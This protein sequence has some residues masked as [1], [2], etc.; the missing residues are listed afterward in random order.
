MEE[1]SLHILDIVQ[2]SVKAQ[3]DTVFITVCEDEKN[4]VLEI[5][6][7]DNGCGM[8]KEFLSRVRDP[9]TTTRKT[10][11]AGLGISLFEAA[12]VQSGGSFDIDSELGKGTR[13]TA[14]FGY[15]SIDR[16]PL[17]DMAETAVTLISGSPDIRFVYTHIKNGSRFVLDTDELKKILGGIS[18]SEPEV[19]SWIK[20]YVREGLINL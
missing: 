3:A 14:R 20:D 16:A 8:S 9:F 12:A 5:T 10:R 7:T 6:V 1:L 13:V 18:L 15:S 17:G 19:L 11:K 2:N 4:D